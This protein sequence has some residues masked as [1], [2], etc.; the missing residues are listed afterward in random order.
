[1]DYHEAYQTLR[2]IID[3]RRCGGTGCKHCVNTGREAI[4][5]TEKL[6]HNQMVKGLRD[7]VIWGGFESLEME[8]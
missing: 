4:S 5:A 1:M 8:V 6:V 3:C 2:Y 7:Q